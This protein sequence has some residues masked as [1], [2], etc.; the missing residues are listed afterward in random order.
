MIEIIYIYIYGDRGYWDTTCLDGFKFVLSSTPKFVKNYMYFFGMW[1][2]YV[3]FWTIGT[4]NIKG[5]QSQEGNCIASTDCVI[6][7]VYIF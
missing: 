7:F 3:N 5:E 1:A 6:V 2:Y 4:S